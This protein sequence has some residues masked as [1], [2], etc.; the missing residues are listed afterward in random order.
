MAR[1]KHLARKKKLT[2]RNRWTKWAPV[3]AVL[4]AFKN[5]KRKHPF[6]ITEVK[7]DWK[8]SKLKV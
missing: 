5:N 1:Y 8:R 6:E 2:K 4:K 7:R 3:W